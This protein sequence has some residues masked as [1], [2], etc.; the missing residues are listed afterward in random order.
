MRRD[1]GLSARRPVL[2][3]RPTRLADGLGL[4]EFAAPSP[5]PREDYTPVVG[6]PVL[7]FSSREIKPYR[8]RIR[9]PFGV[10]NP[11]VARNS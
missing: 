7:P 1:S 9:R 4:K 8:S 2:F 10:C 3:Q 5:L 6:S 11:G